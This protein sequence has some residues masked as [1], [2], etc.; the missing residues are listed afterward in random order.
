VPVFLRSIPYN[1]F[2]ILTL[3]L[4]F[5]AAA[6]KLPLAGKMK[7]A[8][9]RVEKG[10]PLWPPN[11]EQFLAE[12]HNAPRGSLTNLLLPLFVLPAASVTAGTVS[13]GVLSVN[14][15]AGL[16]ITL[17]VMFVMY[18]F[19]RLMTPEEFFDNIIVG[20]EHVLVPI[21]LL[22][23]TFCFSSG[24]KQIGVVEWLG[25]IIPSVIGENYRLLPAALF[26]VFTAITV[27][28]GSSWSIYAIGLPI[29]VQIAAAVDGNMALY[30]G[31][32][33]AAGIAGDSLSIHQSDNNDV[34]S[35]VGCEPT[36]LFL[37]RLPYFA[38]ITGLSFVIYLVV[39]L[40]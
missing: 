7:A 19:Q 40:V 29:A 14:I 13:K 10:G 1:V 28:W 4:V 3:L 20:V 35:A 16:L 31:A 39:G 11:S 9:E 2:A 8:H 24:I 5:T 18:C 12:D 38:F 32:V 21:L 30:A 37:A 17:L 25:H 27:V 6:G 23:L 34:A 22:I 26:L 33:C 36:A 15:G